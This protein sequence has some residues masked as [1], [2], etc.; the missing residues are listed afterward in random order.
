MRRI[1]TPM[2]AAIISLMVWG[3]CSNAP[4]EQSVT[5]ES[6]MEVADDTGQMKI[7]KEVADSVGSV[8]KGNLM[9]AMGEGGPVNAVEFCSTRAL[10]LTEAFNGKYGVSVRR[11]SDRLRNPANAPTALEQQVIADYRAAQAAGTPPVPMVVLDAEGRK[12]FFAPIF[13][14]GPCLIC[15]GNEANM[16]ESLRAKLT[17]LYPEDNATGFN[18]DE[19]RGIWSVVFVKG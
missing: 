1:Q 10:P 17:E 5:H 7:G 9:K 19:L 3:G 15:H 4:E 13:T 12:V 6:P 8:L 11:T 18:I 2:A 14:G 16:D